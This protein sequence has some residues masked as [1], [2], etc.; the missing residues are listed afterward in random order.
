MDINTFWIKLKSYEGETFKTVTGLEFTYHFV[1]DN[2][3][4]TSRTKYNLTKANFKKALALCP[5]AQPGDIAKI[6]RGSSYV[7]SIISDKR[8]Q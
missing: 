7:Y 8:M 1:S 6:I 2:A 3:I 5:I 4:C